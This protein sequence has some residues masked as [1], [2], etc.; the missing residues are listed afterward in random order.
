MDPRIVE[1]YERLTAGG[2][3][4]AAVALL[5]ATATG[6]QDEFGHFRV[7][8]DPTAPGGLR[9]AGAPAELGPWRRLL[10]AGA[11]RACVG[12]GPDVFTFDEAMLPHYVLLRAVRDTSGRA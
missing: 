1:F 6:V 7:V 12:A 3:D 10:E 5:R 9:V 2:Q 11:I 8:A 4:A